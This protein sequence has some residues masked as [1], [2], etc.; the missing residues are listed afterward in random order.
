[1]E[2][3]KRNWTSMTTKALRVC[4]PNIALKLANKVFFQP[5]RKASKW[6]KHVKQIEFHSRYGRL[7]AYKYGEGKSIWLVHGWAG[8]AYDYWPLMQKLA[9]QG[10]A[11]ISF[12]FPAHGNSPGDFCNLAKMIKSFDDIAE[13]LLTPNM[14]ISHGLGAS[15]IANCRWFKSFNKDLLLVAPVLDLYQLLQSRIALSGFDQ[16]LFEQLINRV[17]K[18]EKV[19]ITELCTKAKLKAFVGQLKVIHDIQ[20]DYAPFSTSQQFSELSKVSLVATNKLGHTKLLHSKRVLNVIESY[21]HP[22][23]SALVEWSNVS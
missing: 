1:M 14:V 19:S 8:C 15:V 4:M 16:V 10:Y 22:A 23:C 6:P 13:S 12:D 5:N 11:T 18:R 17:A 20:D 9:E 21:Q 3:L 2:K 7:K